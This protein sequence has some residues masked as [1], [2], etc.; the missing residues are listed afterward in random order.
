MIFA[1]Y[2]NTKE[3][4]GVFTKG[5]LYLLSTG[6]FGVAVDVR[7]SK[8]TDDLGSEININPETDDR[9]AYPDEVFGVI[10]KEVGNRMPGDVV[11][12]N[13][14]DDDGFLSIKG[15]GFVNASNIQLLDSIIV[16]PEMIVFDKERRR[17]SRISQVDE[18]MRI[19]VDVEN[20]MQ[21][22][23]NFIFP[24]SDGE[25]A[26]VPLLRC[27]DDTGRDNIKNGSIY[28]VR[29]L[30]DDGLLLVEDDAGKEMSF[31]PSRFE[32]V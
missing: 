27:L 13:D 8:V 31:E 14:G 26:I 7:H 3:G 24:V 11:V 18:Q 19:K 9:F 32:F 4:D 2:R 30:D 10:V 17:W 16:K 22:C 5:R 28:R 21:E 23:T 29:G 12:I 25:L 6:V 15:M 1:I 20:E